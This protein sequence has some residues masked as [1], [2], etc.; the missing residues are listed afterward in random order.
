[1]NYV[2]QKGELGALGPKF[3]TIFSSVCWK[4][5]RLYR[6]NTSSFITLTQNRCSLF[7]LSTKGIHYWKEDYE[8]QHVYGKCLVLLGIWEQ[9]AL[10]LGWNLGKQW[11]WQWSWDGCLNSVLGHWGW[12]QENPGQFGYMVRSSAPGPKGHRLSPKSRAHT[13]V[14]GFKKRS[15]E[16]QKVFYFIQEWHKL[17]RTQYT[18]LTLRLG[19][20]RSTLLD[21]TAGAQVGC[22]SLRRTKWADDEWESGAISS[23]HQG[24][25]Y[26]LFKLYATL[27]TGGENP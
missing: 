15:W 14:G 2:Y 11:A 16:K 17:D 4:Q 13:W 5:L 1:M 20:C 12:C 3:Y 7:I 6:A 26:A 10:V 22:V 19:I 24:I 9:K 23:Q 25:M 27:G 8:Y 18:H 21:L